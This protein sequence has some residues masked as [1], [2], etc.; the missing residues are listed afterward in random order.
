[1]DVGDVIG[2]RKEAGKEQGLGERTKIIL[3]A[4]V[5]SGLYRFIKRL[6]RRRKENAKQ[7]FKHVNFSIPCFLL[8]GHTSESHEP[9]A[10][11]LTSP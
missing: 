1:M 7:N 3:G 9:N 10:Q 4:T 8:L 11:F 6:R 5:H 2:M